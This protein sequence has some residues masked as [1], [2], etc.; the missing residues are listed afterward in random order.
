MIMTIDSGKS[1]DKT[2]HAL[3]IKFLERKSL[4]RKYLNR[5]NAIYGRPTANTTPNVKTPEAIP[6]K[7]GIRNGCPGI[8]CFK[9][10]ILR[11][12]GRTIREEHQKILGKISQVIPTCRWLD[13]M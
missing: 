6:L 3:K 4:E 8:P 12:A 10:T 7:S 11:S 1:F 2:Q 13:T 5:I 9:N